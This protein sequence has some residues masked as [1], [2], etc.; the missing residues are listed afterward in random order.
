MEFGYTEEQ[1][2]V[3]ETVRDF[4]E[5]ELAPEALRRDK[6]KQFARPQ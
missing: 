6:E 3:R 1:G 2:M 4:A 5:S